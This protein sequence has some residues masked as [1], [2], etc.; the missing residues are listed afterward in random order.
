MEIIKISKEENNQQLL[1]NISF[2]IASKTKLALLA[3]IAIGLIGVLLGLFSK[4]PEIIWHG[5]LINTIFFIGIGYA[6][7]VFS[8][9]FTISDAF[10][11]RSI[12]RLAEAF[13]SFI[14]IGIIFF[15]ILFFGGEYFFEWYDHDKVIHSKEWWLNVKF[16]VIRHLVSLI[17]VAILSYFYIKNSVRADIGLSISLQK[18]NFNNNFAASFIKNFGNTENEIKTGYH[19]NKRIAPILSLSITLITSM[20]AFDWMMSID[21]EWFSTMFGV[22]YLISSLIGAG[23]LLMIITGFFRIRFK[24]QDYISINRYHDLTK[25]T[26]VFTLLWCYMIFSQVI[27]IWYANLPEETPFLI[28]RMK[29]IEWSWLFWVIFVMLFIT[30][31]FGLMSRT[32]CRSIW[33]SRII[34]VVI[35]SGVWLEKYFIVTPSLQENAVANG[36]YGEATINKITGFEFLPFLVDLLIGIGILGIFLGCFFFF[37]QRIP[38]VPISDYRFFK[39]TNH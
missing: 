11:G 6:G 21:Q 30:P 35:L 26:F 8:L 27:V 17:L 16:F 7:L 28:L 31:F 18:E 19:K 5:L 13:S 32:A 12:K 1:K 22:Q 38:L 23:A 3:L 14:P 2:R 25:L 15:I 29:S 4:H 39:D 9:I 34:A 24:L 36:S 33:F 10:W 20:I 37:I